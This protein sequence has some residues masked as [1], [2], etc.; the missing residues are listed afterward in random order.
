MI[1]IRP[2]PE[3]YVFDQLVR[4][5]GNIFLSSNPK[6]TTEQWARKD[7]WKII[8]KNL[9]H[10]YNGICAYSAHWIPFTDNPNIDHYIPK[11]I[12]PDLAYEWDNY[13][14]TCSYVNTVKKDFQDVLDPFQICNDMFFL[15]FPSLLVIANPALTETEKKKVGETRDRLKLND[16]RYISV[17]NRW[18]KLYCRE[19]L[20]FSGLKKTL[21]LLPMS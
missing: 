19:G 7:Y 9:Y 11:S 13:R 21:H 4:K 15:D 8:R 1:P 10:T 16:E 12:R 17:R 6:P 3:P 18:L 20:T 14:L 2:Q 5:K